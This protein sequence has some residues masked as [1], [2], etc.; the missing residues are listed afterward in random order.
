MAVGCGCL[1]RRCRRARTCLTCLQHAWRPCRRRPGRSW[2][3]WRAWAAGSISVCFRSPPRVG[4]GRGG[5]LAPAVE[6]GLLVMEPGP[7]DV[8]RF[9]HDRVR[10]GVL[11]DMAPQ[12]RRAV[13]LRLA[14]RLA[15]RPELFAVAAHQYLPVVD[16]VDDP[17]ERKQVVEL[18]R[19]A[20]DEAKLTSN[21]P[22]VE[23]AAVG[24]GPADGAGGRRRNDRA[25]DR[26]AWWRCTDSAGWTRPT[27]STGSSM[28][29]RANPLRADGGDPRAG[30]QPGQ[31]V[32][33][34]R[35]GHPRH[36]TAAA[37]SGSP[38]HGPEQI[39]AE[40]E[41]GLDEL[42]RWLDQTSESDDLARPEVTDPSLLAAAALIN[43]MMP[44]TFQSDLATHGLA[45]AARGANVGRQRPRPYPGRPGE[46]HAR[47]LRPGSDRTTAPG[48]KSRAASSRSARRGATSPMPPRPVSCTLSARPLVRTAGGM[49]RSGPPC[50][51]RAPAGRGPAERVLD[52]RR[53]GVRAVGLLRRRWTPALP[54][55]RQRWPSPDAPETTTAR[56]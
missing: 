33:P 1:E 46:P 32:P 11:A 30:V 10:E 18:F 24:G 45:R 8:F 28:G 48:T 21:Y 15:S 53:P 51:G 50:N 39:D 19:R 9:R 2:R 25:A 5:Q 13:R 31:S 44:P 54:R 6:D 56:S 34:E 20:A 49:R 3:P 22:V 52:R 47:S 14:R 42:Y 17:A 43:R 16:A 35:G 38:Y 4:A 7:E 23:R 55:W 12:Q 29:C 40:I 41:R 36:R 37:A 27:R 26:P